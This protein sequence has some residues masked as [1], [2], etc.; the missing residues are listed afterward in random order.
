VH[1]LSRRQPRKKGLHLKE[2]GLVST[3]ERYAMFY[4]DDVH[5]R[6]DAARI[7]DVIKMKVFEVTEDFLDQHNVN[8]EDFKKQIQ[9]FIEKSMVIT[10]GDN[11]G[12]FSVGDF[13][14]LTVSNAPEAE[15]VLDLLK[16][17][18]KLLDDQ[19]VEDRHTALQAINELRD[20]ALTPSDRAG[21]WGSLKKLAR[22]IG[23]AAG[24][25]A[26]LA[27]LA[28]AIADLLNIRS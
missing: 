16:Q 4:P 12:N 11:S 2:T 21:M 28:A 19:P 8:T 18:R 6:E 13:N 10:G 20:E 7:L 22:G 27:D 1:R 5:H 23:S 26:P 14:N 15:P 3:R 25:A 24:Y 17:I 9:V